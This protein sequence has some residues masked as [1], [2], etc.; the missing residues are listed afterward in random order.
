MVVVKGFA[1][2]R[3]RRLAAWRVENGTLRD[4]HLEIH[5]TKG[6]CVNPACFVEAN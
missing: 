5:R 3:E 6:K 4:G 1:A 2:E